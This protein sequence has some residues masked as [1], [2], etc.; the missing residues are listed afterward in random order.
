MKLE[1]VCPEGLRN[2]LKQI[3]RSGGCNPWKVGKGEM[4][5]CWTLTGPAAF[6]PGE[7]LS[8]S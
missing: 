4:S 7:G 5:L 1:E 2:S 3:A 8:H 6:T